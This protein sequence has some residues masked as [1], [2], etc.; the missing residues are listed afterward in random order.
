MQIKKITSLVLAAALSIS[1]AAC[2]NSQTTAVTSGQ[3][4]QQAES[5]Q[6]AD[7]SEAKDP[8]SAQAENKTED[9]QAET[10]AENESSA[11]N[12]ILILYF[13]A[14][15]T[16]DVDAVS[17]ATPMT[18]GTSSVEWIANIIH[19]NVGGELIPII[20]S[21]DYPLEYRKEGAR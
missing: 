20:P 21:E 9:Q 11:G 19:D 7:S 2:G 8:E 3:D 4:N 12:N 1:L 13:S 15:N 6:T 18:D 10:A 17:S 14:D 5:T 16:K